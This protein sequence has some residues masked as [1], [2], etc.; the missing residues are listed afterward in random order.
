MQ[1]KTA[2]RDNRDQHK[3]ATGA[4]CCYCH[5]RLVSALYKVRIVKAP[6][7]NLN[8]VAFYYSHVGCHPRSRNSEAA[9]FISRHPHIHIGGLMADRQTQCEFVVTLARELPDHSVGAIAELARVAMRHATIHRR[10]A[11]AL[12]NG[13]IGEP[14]YE[15]RQHRVR[16]RLS[17]LFDVLGIGVIFSGDPRGPTVRLKFKSR[18]SNSSGTGGWSVPTS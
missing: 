13:E 8:A 6:A 5:D 16:E 3:F 4:S 1:V 12:C 18:R 2:I 9:G 15:Q 14:E 17:Q 10:L 11:L 7:A